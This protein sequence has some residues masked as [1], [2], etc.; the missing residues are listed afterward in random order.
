MIKGHAELHATRNYF[1]KLRIDKKLVRCNGFF[2]NLPIGI[3]TYLGDISNEHTLAYMDTI[4]YGLTHGINFLDTAINYREMRSERDIGRVLENL[5][6]IE[7]KL[8]REEVIVASKS[9]YLYGDYSVGLT[10]IKYLRK[11]LIPNGIVSM[12]DINVFEEDGHT[13]APKF[14]DESIEK[15]KVNLGLSTI[16]IYY[17]HNPEVSRYVL[18][19]ELF[20]N[21]LHDLFKSLENQVDKRN[22]RFYGLATWYG[23]LEDPDSKWYISLEKVIKI[24][25]SAGGSNHHFRFI[26][27]PFNKINCIGNIK[28][29]QIVDNKYCTLI[30]AANKLN[31]TVTTSVPLNQSQ[32]LTQNKLTQEEMLKYV[33][34]I[35]GIQASMVGTKTKS[36]LLENLKLINLKS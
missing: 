35:P 26:Q 5:I 33:I 1:K 12:E 25:K 17:I 31:L 23:F 8:K 32:D 19:S 24:A 4:S 20:Y 2:C 29:N 34:N 14:Y 7:K 16:D 3:G 27:F 10:P 11:I 21:Q 30:D 15:S 13:L 36:H 28:K 6:L 9:G 18:G 22:I